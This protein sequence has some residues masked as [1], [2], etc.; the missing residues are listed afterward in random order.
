MKIE[1]GD[2]H[3]ASFVGHILEKAIKNPS[4]LTVVIVGS[5]RIETGSGAGGV[6]GNYKITDIT[7]EVIQWLI[8]KLSI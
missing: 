3:F 7:S 2:I 1:Q 8:L 5:P 4:L 6:E